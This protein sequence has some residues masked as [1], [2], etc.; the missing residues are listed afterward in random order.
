V[1]DETISI[2]KM[3]R[4]DAAAVSHF[5]GGGSGRTR[6]SPKNMLALK[7]NGPDE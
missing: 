4:V 2:N 6:N 7:A 1:I 3:R 5:T